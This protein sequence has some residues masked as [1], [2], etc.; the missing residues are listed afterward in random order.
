ME[1]QILYANSRQ[2]VLSNRVVYVKRSLPGKVNI[3]VS[4]NQEVIPYDVLGSSS[5]NP[6]FFS[7]NLAQKL[8]V[9]IGDA[10]KYLQRPIGQTIFKGELL[11][12]KKGFFGKTNILAPTDGVIE[13]YSNQTGELRLKFI[14]RQ[15]P[16]VAGVY[17]II[18]EVN[19]QTGEILIKTLVTEIRGIYGTGNEKGGFLNVLGNRGDLV[20]EDQITPDLAGHILVSGSLIYGEALRQAAGHGIAG[21]ISGG[22]N[23]DDFKSIAGSIYLQSQ[24]PQVS[25]SIIGTE[26]FGLVPIGDDLFNLI[27]SY[28]D[29][30]VF[31]NGKERRLWLP[32]N[33]SDSILTLRKTALPKKDLPMP[34]L[35][36]LN[37]EP[38]KVG[39]KVRII[40]PPFMGS[41]GKIVSI[42]KSVTVLESGISTYLLTIE[43]PSRK[44]KVPYTNIEIIN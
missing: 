42:D 7:I 6:G 16:L 32:S 37:T 38:I 34:G 20:S 30:F 33:S 3:T 10:L 12:S 27:K 9:S 40:W 15:K 8:G 1:D 11:A 14:P 19:N 5:I 39:F 29:K 43:T 2:R 31:I 36:E 44:I 26:G 21:I 28:N 17:G 25:I 24:S 23:V 41:Q 13:S 35:P 4:K 22:F 18:E